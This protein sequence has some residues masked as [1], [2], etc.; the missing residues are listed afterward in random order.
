MTNQAVNLLPWRERQERKR[1]CTYFLILAMSVILPCFGAFLLHWEKGKEV[2]RLRSEISGY[3]LA[4][5]RLGEIKDEQELLT[6]RIAE[7]DSWLVEYEVIFERRLLFLRFWSELARH[8]PDSM[9]YQSLQLDRS[10]LN[11]TG[12]TNSSPDLATYMRRLEASSVFDSPRLID[13]EDMSA[14]HQFGIEA[15]L[16]VLREA[17]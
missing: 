17:A 8:L 9:H 16:A 12:M 13:L 7:A 11:L 4:S 14:G 6:S 10:S 1:Q 2:D 15:N 3:R 5:E